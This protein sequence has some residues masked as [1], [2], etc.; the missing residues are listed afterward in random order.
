[1]EHRVNDKISRQ[2]QVEAYLLHK[3]TS[4][5]WKTGDKIRSERDLSVELGVSRIT[6]RNAILHLTGKGLFARKTGQGTFVKQTMTEKKHGTTGAENISGTIGYVICKEKS[7][8]KPLLQEAFYF[9]V[10]S[11]IEEIAAQTGRHVL[12]TYIDDFNP[13]ELPRFNS[14]LAKVDGLIIEEAVNTEFLDR[15]RLSGRPTVLLAPT[16]SAAGFDTVT[17]DVRLGIRKA[18]KYLFSLGH[19]RIGILNGPLHLQTARLRYEGWK[20]AMEQLTGSVPEELAGG[21]IGWTAEAGHTGMKE[22]LGKTDRPTA[23]VCANDLIAFGALSAAFEMKLSVPDDISIVGFDDS[24]TAELSTP[25]LTTMKIYSH[26]MAHTAAKRLLERLED[27][28]LPAIIT[29]FPI[30][31]IIRKSCREVKK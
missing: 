18:V 17:F 4:G 2:A 11:G 14:F 23:V 21:N 8:Q 10:F 1:L 31:L 30:D 19:T 3:I 13:D 28:D 12:F 15:I 22:L 5:Q 7:V 24:E 20:T 25:P 29:E 6:I 9:D 27:T 16:V 26:Q